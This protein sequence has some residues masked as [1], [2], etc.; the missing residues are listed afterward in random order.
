MQISPGM[1]PAGLQAMQNGQPTTA[2]ADLTTHL[3]QME[4]AKHMV[5]AGSKVIQT[6][7]E[8]LGTLIDTTA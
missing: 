8:T 7:D 5:E 2:I 1:M 4:Q 6:A 3:M